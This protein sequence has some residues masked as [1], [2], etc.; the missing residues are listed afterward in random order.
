MYCMLMYCMHYLLDYCQRNT[1]AT[2]T[3]HEYLFTSPFTIGIRIL[4]VTV[5]LVTDVM[6][7]VNKMQTIWI[8]TKG[9]LA[10]RC[11]CAPIKSE[12]PDLLTPSARANPP[13]NSRTTLQGN[14]ACIVG[15]STREPHVFGGCD[16]SEI[17]KFKSFLL[18]NW[19]TKQNMLVFYLNQT[20]GKDGIW[21]E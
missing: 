10:N 8:S 9:R 11:S 21:K 1:K 5:L 6:H 15:Q 7:I 12:S 3:K 14:F 16:L 20:L 18:L 17:S 2:V 13:P 4:A 19:L